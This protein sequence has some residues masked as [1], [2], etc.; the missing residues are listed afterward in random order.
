MHQ[1]TSL[2]N[3]STEVE[4]NIRT[5]PEIRSEYEKFK[6]IYLTSLAD[7]QTPSSSVKESILNSIK[8][9]GKPGYPVMENIIVSERKV[10]SSFNYLMAASIVFLVTSLIVNFYL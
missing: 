4:N 7:L 8:P 3:E 6:T 5:Y 10:S 2:E 9:S 1:V